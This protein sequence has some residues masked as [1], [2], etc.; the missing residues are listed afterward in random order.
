M[1]LY[2]RYDTRRVDCVRCGVTVEHLPWAD[3]GAW[4]TRPSRTTSVTWP[5]AYTEAAPNA[6][7]VFDRFHV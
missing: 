3:V 2:L 5:S 4:F 1:K 7:I 6:E